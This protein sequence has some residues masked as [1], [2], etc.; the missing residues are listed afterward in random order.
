MVGLGNPGSPYEKTRHNVGWLF[1]DY[2]ARD[3]KVSLK[4]GKGSFWIAEKE[5]RFLVKPMTYVNFSGRAV[6]ELKE[7]FDLNEREEL[8]V[9]LDDVS[10][11]FGRIRLRMKGGSG[12]HK[13]LE[14][15]VFL[16]GSEEVPRLRI[17]I[18]KEE[19]MTLR[20]WVLSPFTEEEW[21]SL[22][23]IF[24]RVLEGVNIL[25]ER[26]ADQAMEFVNSP[27]LPENPDNL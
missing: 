22:P 20:E 7:Q 2:V 16:L 19:G 9:L 12:G 11:P 26:G 4:P 27:D 10:L 3:W 17:G 13:G 24:D 18:G 23:E 6:L 25:W 8:L 15:I 14:S 21:K 5:E 1:I